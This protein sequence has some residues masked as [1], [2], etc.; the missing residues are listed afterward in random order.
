MEK[1][2]LEDEQVIILDVTYLHQKII[3]AFENI[4]AYP[5]YLQIY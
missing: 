5:K 4:V 2:G 3:I 1:V